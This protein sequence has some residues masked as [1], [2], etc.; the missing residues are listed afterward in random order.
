MRSRLC[1]KVLAVVLA[2]YICVMPVV[3]YALVPA[4][5]LALGAECVWTAGNL[6]RMWPVL[7]RVGSKAKWIAV[8]MAPKLAKVIAPLVVIGAATNPAVQE[9]VK[10]WVQAQG[11]MWN[12]GSMQ[13]PGVMQA[14]FSNM[15]AWN[16]FL[17][18]NQNRTDSYGSTYSYSYESIVDRSE[19][20]LISEQAEQYRQ[21][22]LTQYP[23]N[24][25]GTK[26]GDWG[27]VGPNQYDWTAGFSYKSVWYRESCVPPAS[28]CYKYYYRVWPYSMTAN[29]VIQDD[30]VPPIAL[31]VQDIAQKIEEKG[32]ADATTRDVIEA[33]EPVAREILAYPNVGEGVRSWPLDATKTA[34]QG[35]SDAIVSEIP[36][37]ILDSISTTDVAEGDVWEQ[38]NVPTLPYTGGSVAELG[39]Y[40]PEIG[41]FVGRFSQFISEMK[42]TQL[43]SLPCSFFS[44][45]PSGGQSTMTVDLGETYGGRHTVDFGAWTWLVILKAVVLV[46]FSYVAI[47]IVVLKR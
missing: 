30:N 26:D 24:N 31:T 34:A 47:R 36:Q 44:G 1:C 19:V 12:N 38:P 7:I 33:V 10:T 9:K 20:G 13:K 11:W 8:D 21:S 35:L 4:A 16:Y 28:G 3:S 17:D 37:S 32:V 45:V 5:A 18:S 6:A 23:S 22:L 43:F 39:E 27:L 25:V 40:Q 2:L 15:S 41:D 14:Q 42:A 29:P 46:V